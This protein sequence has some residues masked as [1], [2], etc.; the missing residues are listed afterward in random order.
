MLIIIINN[1]TAWNTTDYQD[2]YNS[3]AKPVINI[4]NNK[5]KTW[6]CIICRR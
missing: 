4:I 6:H 5:K 3:C 2:Y 1:N